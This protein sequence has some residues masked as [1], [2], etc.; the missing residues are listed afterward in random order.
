MDGL[1]QYLQACHVEAEPVSVETELMLSRVLANLASAIANSG[2]IITHDELPVVDADENIEHVFQNLVSNA[3]KYR[4]PD[5]APRIH[6]SAA[7][8]APDWIFSVRDN[9]VGIESEFADS[10]FEVF[11]RLHGRDIAG[12]GI[13]LA[14]AKRVVEARGGRMW[15]E[16]EPGTGSTFYFTLPVIAAHAP[17]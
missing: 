1:L 9:G 11:R 10:I 13:G 17:C 3:I 6:V 16:S 2:A 8:E 14:L 15:V 7:F 12:H 5:I 4:R